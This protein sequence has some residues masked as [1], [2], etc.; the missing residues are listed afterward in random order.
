ME[1]GIEIINPSTGEKVD[2]GKSKLCARRAVEQTALSRVFLV[3]TIFMPPL[4]LIAIE[5]A[6]MMPRN[7]YLKSLVEGAMIV[8]EL[9]LAVPTGIAM[10]PQRG[11]ILAS[12][13]E[14]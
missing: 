6:N 4:A 1:Q 12:D 14:P 11:T 2:V 9:Y 3:V 8:G 7:F 13:L 10:F 5:R